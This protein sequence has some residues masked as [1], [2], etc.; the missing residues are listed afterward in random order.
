LAGRAASLGK[1]AGL[2]SNLNRGRV[3]GYFGQ[4]CSTADDIAERMRRYENL[5][6]KL[7]VGV[8]G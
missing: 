8:L 2:S 3:R 6:V 4:L 1:P 7:D 5:L